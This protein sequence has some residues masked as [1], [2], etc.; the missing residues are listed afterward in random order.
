MMEGMRN[1]M[2]S[3]AMQAQGGFSGTRQGLITAYDPNEHAVKV[4]LQPTGE[5]T[6]W[7]PLSSPWVGNGW[8]LAVG[9]EIGAVCQVDFDSG[10]MGT[11]LVGGQFWNGEDRPPAVPSGE[12]WLVH[13]SG[14]VLK[15]HN[16]G[17]VELVSNGTLTSTAPQWNHN[18]P[19]TVNGNVVINGTEQVSGKITGQGGMAVSGGSGASVSGNM[20]ITG[21]DVKADSISLKGH[22]HADP[23]GGTVGVAQ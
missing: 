17:A 19:M 15:F 9:P 20:T 5:E 13:K 4:Q 23:Q 7:V 14:S 6:G 1:M 22:T 11:A 8:G 10:Q 12:F 18:G 3:Q 21:G 16:G 2:R